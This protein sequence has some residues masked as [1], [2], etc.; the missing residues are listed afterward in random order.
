MQK[1]K[2]ITLNPAEIAR[3]RAGHPWVYSKSI[4]SGDAGIEAGDQVRVV[5]PRHDVI[6]VGFYHP[7]SKIRIRIVRREDAPI[8]SD[9]LAW[10]I[11]KAI[12]YRKLCYPGRNVIRL[13]NSE[14]DGLSG[15]IIDRYD[16]AVLFQISSLGMERMKDSIIQ[17]IRSVIAPSILIERNDVSNRRFEGLPEIRHIHE[18]SLS[19][20]ALTQFTVKLAGLTYHLD[21]M[22]GNKTG[23]YLDQIEN[24]ELSKPIIAAHPEARVLDCFSYIGGFSLTAASCENTRSVIGLDQSAD[25]VRLAA[26]NATTNGVDSRCQFIQT[27]VFDWLRNASSGQS[28]VAQDPFD[29]I[30]LDPPSF[31]KNRHTVDAAIRGYKELH[32]R[33]LKLLKPGGHLLTYSC[34]HHIS[35]DLLRSIAFEASLD[36]HRELIESHAFYQAKDHPV[37]PCVPETFYLKGFAYFTNN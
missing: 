15:L 26:L 21:L 32:V 9:W 5:G 11:Q 18:S 14:S 24:H 4:A 33:A 36:T 23:L 30:I 34:S 10:R 13:V 25:A 17:A 7:D 16:D 2:T 29:V 31:T 1:L 22:N 19:E 35:A 20:E 27:N 28:D 8:D 6:G 37:V 3:I 12:D